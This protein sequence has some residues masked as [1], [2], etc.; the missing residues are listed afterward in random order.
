MTGAGRP[1][2]GPRTHFQFEDDEQ[3]EAV[4][5][6]AKQDGADQAELIRGWIRSG[7][8]ARKRWRT[9]RAREGGVGRE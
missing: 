7:L 8:I 1:K 4:R 5:E 3:A 6:A 2:K 9:R